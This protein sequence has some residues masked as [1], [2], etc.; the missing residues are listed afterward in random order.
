LLGEVTVV[1]RNDIDEPVAC[2]EDVGWSRIRRAFR[3][4]FL[5]RLY[6]PTPHS[7]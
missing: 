5:L 4:E 2:L 1:R 6:V 3:S 7:R